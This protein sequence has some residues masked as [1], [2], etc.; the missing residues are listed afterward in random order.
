MHLLTGHFYKVRWDSE[1]LDGLSEGIPDGH[2][3]LRVHRNVSIKCL[4]VPFFKIFKKIT[5][6][7]IV[8]NN[9]VISG[10]YS[11]RLWFHENE[12]PDT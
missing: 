12:Y 1:R 6:K 5:G 11:Y 3:N 4:Y 8:E 9:T 7:I 2:N 10:G